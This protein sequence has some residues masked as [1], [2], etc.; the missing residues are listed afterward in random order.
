MQFTYNAYQDLLKLLK[1]E[2]YKICQYDNWQEGEKVCILR[3]DVD[4][5]LKAAEIFSQIESRQGVQGI[6]F[7]LLNTDFYNVAS[8]GSQRIISRILENGGMIGLHFDETFYQTE[9]SEKMN[10]LGREEIPKA[11]M[12]EAKIL[13]NLVGVPIRYVSMHRP[14][15]TTLRANYQIEGVIN[16]YNNTFFQKFKYISDSRRNWRQNP[17][18]IIISGEYQKLHI[19]THAFWYREKELSATECLKKY[20][21]ERKKQIYGSLAD[22]IRNIEEFLLPEEAELL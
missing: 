15:Q 4:M 3:H 20:I 18:Q 11:I 22:N 19:L 1:R 12:K 17:E 6:Y 13:E 8:A 9:Y 16:S 21:I 10:I 2:N 7:I 14:S 5:S